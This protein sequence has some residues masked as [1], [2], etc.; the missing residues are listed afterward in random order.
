MRSFLCVLVL[1]F[2]AGP[3]KADANADTQIRKCRIYRMGQT[4]AAALYTQETQVQTTAD[5]ETHWNSKISDP[6]G[7]VVMT[8][9]AVL[10]GLSVVS[11]TVEQRQSG[12]SYELKTADGQAQFWI[13]KWKDGVRGEQ[14]DKN[15]EKIGDNFLMG[16]LT[17]PYIL[18]NWAALMQGESLKVEFGIFELAKTIGFNFK[19]VSETETTVEIQMKPSSFVISMLVDPLVLTFTKKD[20]KMIRFKGRTP[21][22]EILKGKSKPLDAEI[23]YD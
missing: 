15:Q 14:V 1:I 20:P 18:K 2:G 21:L 4:D 12:E 22:R 9:T 10:K 11:Q 8:E 13:Y 23:I 16:P 19:K 6:D 5:G 17:E 7:Q 3:A